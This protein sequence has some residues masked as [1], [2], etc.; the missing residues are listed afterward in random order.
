MFVFFLLAVA[1]LLFVLAP[2]LSSWGQVRVT[3][4][5]PK[6]AARDE[7]AVQSRA[8]YDQRMQELAEEDMDEAQRTELSDELGSVLLAE[9]PS[10]EAPLDDQNVSAQRIVSS[11]F[12]ARPANL[13]LIT[14]ALLVALAVGV[15]GQLGSF[16]ASKIQGAQEV[17]ALSPEN[18]LEAL[19][20]WQ[21][22]LTEWLVEEPADAQS[23]YLLGHAHLK[24]GVFSS[25]ERAFAQ[26]HEYANSDVSVKFYWLQARYLDRQGVLD[27]RSR[28][29]AQEILTADPNSPQVLEMLAVAAI[30]E[31]NA[32]EAIT[33]LNRTLNSEQRP[34]RVRAT[35]DAI[36]A[37]RSAYTQQGGGTGI[38]V[39]VR[40]QQEVDPR[41]VIFVVARPI[42]GG[43]P[44]A[45]VR[46]PSWLLP[47]S[48]N[49]DDLV[50]M[51]PDRPL[52]EAD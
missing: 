17:L 1:A 16:G 30:S 40:A 27:D 11:G 44:Y 32:A 4:R 48:V 12:L 24:Q 38:Q 49:L 7:A 20:R 51:S 22:L 43:M 28:Q 33:L 45:V 34:E 36:G 25:A 14:G 47:F 13:L 46:R 6:D 3:A 52:S 29:L 37:L 18:D 41:A 2:A 21:T 42:G 35:V 15:Y 8:W 39:N 50:S 26:A 19:Q 5:A 9:Y 23:W 10:V 31:G